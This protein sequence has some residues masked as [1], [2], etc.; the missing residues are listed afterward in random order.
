MSR[1]DTTSLEFQSLLAVACCD[2][3]AAED[4]AK[5]EGVVCDEPA[6]EL[7]IDFF[8]LDGELHRL[9]RQ[10]SGA[11]KCFE[12]LGLGT[13]RPG[14]VTEPATLPEPPSLLLPFLG[15]A[16]HGTV[17]YVSSGWPM[18]YLV[19]T[20]IFG[21]GLLIGSHVYVSEPAQVA[22]QSVPL[23]SHLSPLPSMVGRIT[24]MV[25]CQWKNDGCRMTNDEL[26]AQE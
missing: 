17:G 19:A 18:A 24:G 26:P 15:N 9:V 10:E 7:V 16:I 23:P 3:A 21:I 6:M 8:Q 11:E 25:D 14:Q 13:A 5:L 22:R 20:V 1:L 4:L 12:I 2:D